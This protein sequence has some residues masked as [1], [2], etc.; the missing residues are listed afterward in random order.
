MQVFGTTFRCN[1]VRDSTKKDHDTALTETSVPVVEEQ[2]Q[3]GSRE[4]VTERVVLSKKVGQREELIEVPLV[5]ENYRIKRI[6]MNLPVDSP[7][8]V[9]HVGDTTIVP[10]VEEV[11]VINKQLILREE[12]HITRARTEVRLP[13]RVSLKR[14][15]IDVLTAPPQNLARKEFDDPG[16]PMANTIVGL[17]DD[18]QKAQKVLRELADAGFPASNIGCIT[19]NNASSSDLPS[20]LMRA[21]V[22]TEEVQHYSSEAARGNSV[23]VL[24]SSDEA[25]Q[26]AV[27]ILERNGAKDLDQRRGSVTAGVSGTQTIGLAS[28][29]DRST[30]TA[31]PVV[32]EDLKVGKRQVTAGGVRIYTRISEQPIEQD[33]SLRQEHIEVERRPVDRPATE[34]DLSQFKEGVVEVTATAEQP[35]ISKE[36]KV[37][38]EVVVSKDVSQETRTIRDTVLKTD[39]TVDDNHAYDYGRTLASDPR[40]RGKDWASIEPEAQ[41]EW[42]TRHKGAWDEFKDHVRHAWEKMTGE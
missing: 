32:E 6:P 42:G 38:E 1:P 20:T 26:R 35:V 29:G 8:A 16:V 19:L 22:P 30:T 12:V 13:Q 36:A 5:F 27:A 39:V 41:R 9:R 34:Q 2:I 10:V 28:A 25:V 3:V 24:R 4:V 14:E 18:Q 15:R 23:L 7:P 21:G 17:F 40:Y 31:I 33:V 37:V 11:A